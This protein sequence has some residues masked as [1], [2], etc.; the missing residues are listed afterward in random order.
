MGTRNSGTY[1]TTKG[2]LKPEHLMDELRNSGVKFTEKDVV[3]VTK[4][5]KNEL[6]W[7]EKGNDSRGLKHIIQRHEKDLKK[8]FGINKE[9]IP[10]F[11]KDV[12]NNGKE[13]RVTLKNGKLEKIFL[14]KEKYF[15]VSGVGTNGFIV[16]FY[17][18][19]KGEKQWKRKD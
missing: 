10:S 16:S 19:S 14:Y 1:N 4:T 7:L 18:K 6:V 3:M 13:V 9:N 15:V 5:K 2:A 12:F 8:K 17:P 11:I